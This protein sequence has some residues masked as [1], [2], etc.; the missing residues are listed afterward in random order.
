MPQKFKE[1]KEKLFAYLTIRDFFD[2]YILEDALSF[3]HSMLKAASTNKIWKKSYPYSVVYYIQ[4]LDN[5]ATAAFHIHQNY[6]QRDAAIINKDKM[7]N[8][9]I[10][11]LQACTGRMKRDNCWSCFPRNLNLAQF[12]NPYLAIKSFCTYR[13]QAQWKE[14]FAEIQEN[15]LVAMPMSSSQRPFNLLNIQRQLARLIEACF[16]LEVRTNK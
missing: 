16:L 7:D 8:P 4:H 11:L 5:L 2:I 12:Y 13:S 3:L 9:G 10:E 1:N 15:A 14:I 6:A